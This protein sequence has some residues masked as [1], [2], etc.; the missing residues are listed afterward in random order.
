MRIEQLEY[1]V[2]IANCRSISLAAQNLFT[3]QPNI[4]KAIKSLELELGLTLFVRQKNTIVFTKD[5]QTVLEY[6]YQILKQLEALR[7]YALSQQKNSE[8]LQGALKICYPPQ[9]RPAFS[10]VLPSFCKQQPNIKVSS[11]LYETSQLLDNL[12]TIDSDVF[13]VNLTSMDIQSK[14][15]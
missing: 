15:K 1:L 2:E 10:E 7:N 9:V 5:G 14:K 3:T 6:A 11:V 12:Y 8:K 4:S 13:L